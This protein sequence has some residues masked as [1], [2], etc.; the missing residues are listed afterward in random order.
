VELLVA[1][2]ASHVRS[3]GTYSA[4]RVLEDLREAGYHVGR[5]RIA[6]LL[7]HEGLCGV[8]KRRGPVRP[9]HFVR[10][11]PNAPDLVRRAFTATAPHQLWVAEI[12]Y[13]PTAAGFLYLAVVLDVCSRRV[14]GWADSRIS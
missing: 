6:R 4:P 8:S 1:I 5:K 11:T 10:E 13:V 3:D 14:I 12:T 9:V 2:R 7:R